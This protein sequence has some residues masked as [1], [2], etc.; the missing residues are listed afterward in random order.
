[1][2]SGVI[3]V[4]GGSARCLYAFNPDGT[5]KWKFAT[6]YNMNSSPAIDSDG[7]IYFGCH[8]YYL[9]ALKGVH[10][11]KYWTGTGW[12]LAPVKAWDKTTSQWKDAELKYSEGALWK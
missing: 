1:M 12:V 6:K 9:Y 10:K 3:Y 2:F 4:S 8:D 5:R 7:T 11:L